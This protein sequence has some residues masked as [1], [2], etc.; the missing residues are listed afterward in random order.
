MDVFLSNYLLSSQGD[1]VAMAHSVEIRLPFLDYR[2]IDFAL[3]LPSKWK[4][5]ALNEKYILKHAFNGLV[6]DHIRARKK[7]P[8]RAPI[9][10]AFF[11]DK[12]SPYVR[13]LLSED[14]LSKSDYFN[15]QK[16]KGLVHKYL[17]SDHNISNE[18]QNMAFMG[19]LSTQLI[20]HQFI[21]SLPRPAISMTSPDK[22]IRR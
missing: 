5:H 1:R 21:E 11:K 19:I 17:K 15:S 4:I 13:E 20:H 9:G 6:L 10:E 12:P 16:V 8:Y 3:K 22:V 14:F 18:I 2:V 7:Q